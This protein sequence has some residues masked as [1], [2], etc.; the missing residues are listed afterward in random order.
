MTNLNAGRR[1]LLGVLQRCGLLADHCASAAS[2]LRGADACTRKCRDLAALCRVSSELL[3]RRSPYQNGLLVVCVL[4]AEDCAR[5]CEGH[6]GGFFADS[7]RACRELSSEVSSWHDLSYDPWSDGPGV[8]AS[9][10]FEP[11]LAAPRVELD[12]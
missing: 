4:A 2:H 9:R 3:S 7:A 6:P 12:S 10:R 11:N 5:E 1:R 8:G